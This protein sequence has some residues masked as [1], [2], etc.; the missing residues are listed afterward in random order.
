MC[1]HANAMFEAICPACGEKAVPLL[2][3][4]A[5]AADTLVVA[6]CSSCMAY[7]TIEPSRISWLSVPELVVLPVGALAFLATRQFSV[8]AQAGLLAFCLVFVV[9]AYRAPLSSFVPASTSH[10]GIKRVALIGLIF[11]FVACL[12][13]LAE[14][15]P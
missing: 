12:S 13:A 2:H 6:Q 14:L 3:R 11:G 9:V 10:L 5:A 1:R 7:S 4:V 8:A 15:L